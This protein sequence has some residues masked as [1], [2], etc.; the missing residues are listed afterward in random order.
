MKTFYLNKQE[1]IIEIEI[2]KLTIRSINEK[3]K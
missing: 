2:K 3:R 1:D